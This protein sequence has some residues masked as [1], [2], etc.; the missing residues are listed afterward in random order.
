MFESANLF[1]I[2]RCYIPPGALSACSTRASWLH[3]RQALCASGPHGLMASWPQGS[4]A[5][6]PQGLS[7]SWPYG[8]MYHFLLLKQKCFDAPQNCV[9]MYHFYKLRDSESEPL[10]ILSL[11]ICKSDSCKHNSEFQ[12]KSELQICFE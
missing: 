1:L 11:R 2:Y 9:G 3:I 10:K 12:K 5:P 4:M 8:S 7:A 6:G